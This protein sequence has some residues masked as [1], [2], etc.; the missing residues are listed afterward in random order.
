MPYILFS[1]LYHTN[2]LKVNE[3]MF[4]FHT[5]LHKIR[6]VKL[7]PKYCLAYYITQTFSKS[8]MRFFTFNTFKKIPLWLLSVETL[9]DGE[10]TRIDLVVLLSLYK[11]LKRKYS[12]IN[13]L[14]IDEVVSSLDVENSAKVMQFLKVFAEENNINVFIVSHT[15]LDLD[16]FDEVIEVEKTNGF[17]RICK[18]ELAR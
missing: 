13:L 1:I 14:T 8:I 10:Q 12:S 7:C 6:F 2:I 18:G 11:L 9:S 5:I 15:N 4:I 16:E 17:S 3:L